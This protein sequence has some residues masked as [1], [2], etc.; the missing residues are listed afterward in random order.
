MT[1]KN[2]AALFTADVQE[3]WEN[4]L[5]TYFEEI[6]FFE[7]IEVDDDQLRVSFMGNPTNIWTAHHRA[8]LVFDSDTSCTPRI[9]FGFILDKGDDDLQI[10]FSNVEISRLTQT[11]EAL[12]Q[13]LH[14]QLGG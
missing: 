11:P 6:F 8:Y 12:M 1:I 10:Q 4:V 13:V 14:A 5:I 9:E 7:G 2:I 3:R